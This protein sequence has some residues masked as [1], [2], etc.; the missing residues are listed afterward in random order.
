MVDDA[1]A[2]YLL[3]VGDLAEGEWVYEVVLDYAYG[4]DGQ[5]SNSIPN[6]IIR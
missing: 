6:S 2:E 3:H 1:F 4:E 5:I